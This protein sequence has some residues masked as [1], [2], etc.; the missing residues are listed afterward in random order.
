MTEYQNA[1]S[2]D[3]ARIPVDRIV[4]RKAQIE[5]LNDRVIHNRENVL[6]TG[7]YGVG[8]TCL[9]RKFA[10]SGEF[11]GECARIQRDEWLK[12]RWSFLQ[13]ESKERCWSS[14]DSMA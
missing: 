4:D 12:K 13:V 5:F 6:I 9:L 14:S 2:L 11:V 7:S 1:F 3:T 8:K 10:S